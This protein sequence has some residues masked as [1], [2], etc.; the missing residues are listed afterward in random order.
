LALLN[1]PSR[2]AAAAPSERIAVFRNPSPEFIVSG[3]VSADPQG[4]NDPF[5]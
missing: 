1:G 2:R 5:E 3:S 4:G